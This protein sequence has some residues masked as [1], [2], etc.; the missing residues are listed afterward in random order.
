MSVLCNVTS[1]WPLL[2]VISRMKRRSRECS[3]SMVFASWAKGFFGRHL[4]LSKSLIQGGV[5]VLLQ[6]RTII[7]DARLRLALSRSLPHRAK[8]EGL[9]YGR[10]LAEMI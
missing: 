10:S 3:D 7:Y 4:Q 5:S 2:C 6:H 1:E 8:A 9:C